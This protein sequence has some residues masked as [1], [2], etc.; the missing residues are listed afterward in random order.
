MRTFIFNGNARNVLY[1]GSGLWDKESLGYGFS[2][3]DGC[4]VSGRSRSL[5]RIVKVGSENGKSDNSDL[6]SWPLK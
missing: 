4:L 5:L 3:Q 6:K 1:D 2:C